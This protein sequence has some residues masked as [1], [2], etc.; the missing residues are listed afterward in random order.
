[1]RLSMEFDDSTF[2]VFFIVINLH[3][4]FWTMVVEIV[5]I[6][7]GLQSIARIILLFNK[8]FKN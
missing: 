3:I 1:M 4:I 5:K 6:F 8:L 7:V 2:C